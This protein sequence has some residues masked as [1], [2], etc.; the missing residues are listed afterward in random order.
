MATQPLADLDQLGLNILD[1][2]DSDLRPN[3][4][5]QEDVCLVPGPESRGYS[6]RCSKRRGF[7]VS[8]LY[9]RLD[10]LIRWQQ[11]VVVCLERVCPCDFIVG[12]DGG[13]DLVDVRADALV[14]PLLGQLLTLNDLRLDCL[15]PLRLAECL[16]LLDPRSTILLR[17]LPTWGDDLLVYSLIVRLYKLNIWCRIRFVVGFE[18]GCNG[19]LEL[20]VGL[21]YRGRCG[22]AFFDCGRTAEEDTDDRVPYKKPTTEQKNKS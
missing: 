16:R 7:Q 12:T 8:V 2:D 9:I 3:S 21:A 19:S 22:I 1:I 6:S 17:V 10:I 14:I 5:I 18:M 13:R 4:T 15:F 11:E 20:E